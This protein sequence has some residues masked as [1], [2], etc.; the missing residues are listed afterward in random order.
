[1]VN[2]CA[3]VL[4]PTLCRYEH[5]KECI[6]SLKKNSY[7]Q[8]TDI[9]IALDYPL[10]DAHKSGYEKICEYLK[11]DFSEFKSFNVEKRKY[12]YGCT[13]NSYELE[14]KIREKYENLIY[15][16]DDIVFSPNFLEYMNKALQYSKNKDDIIAVTGYS[17]PVNWA[18]KDGATCFLQQFNCS[19]WGCGY[20]FKDIEKVEADIQ[21]HLMY[22]DFGNI[23]KKQKNNMIDACRIDYIS[24]LYEGEGEKNNLLNR[25]TDV[26]M[27]IY[28]GLYNKKVI[29]PVISKSQNHG[30]D[31][32]GLYCAKIDTDNSVGVRADSFD[33]SN[34][35]IDENNNF[36]FVLDEQNEQTIKININKLNKFDFRGFKIKFKTLIKI[37]LLYVKKSK[38]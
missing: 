21:E 37:L 35:I 19:M 33:Y 31:G 1:M 16:E 8:Y 12:N 15:A 20:W 9:F 36:D 10:K 2:K 38:R 3:P 25:V 4:I 6:E 26:S 14:L 11:N 23:Y 29:S 28:M 5:F 7:A 32:S 22:K 34:Q 13:K 24:C 18:V 17:Y 30:F 27:R